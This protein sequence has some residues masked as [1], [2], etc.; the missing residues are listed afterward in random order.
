M[1]Y[2][3]LLL[4]VRAIKPGGLRLFLMF[5]LMGQQNTPDKNSWRADQP[6]SEE[7]VLE[8]LYHDASGMIT[9]ELL[10]EEILIKRC[11]SVPSTAYLMQ[12][13]VI[14]QGILDELHQCAFDDS[15][16]EENRLLIPEPKD[17]IEL[18][19]SSLS[20]G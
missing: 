17:G 8:M 14:I 3:L 9:I 5:Y 4:S 7:Y 6:S 13:S 1:F 12:E 18:A 20:F 16:E 10:E 15:V 19:R 11:G 2:S